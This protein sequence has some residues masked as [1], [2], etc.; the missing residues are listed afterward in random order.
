[1][2]VADQ[3][4]PQDAALGVELHCPEEIQSRVAALKLVEEVPAR[5]IGRPVVRPGPERVE[6]LRRLV[7]AVERPEVEA[8]Q[9]P[10]PPVVPLLGGPAQN[11]QRLRAEGEREGEVAG[12]AQGGGVFGKESPPCTHEGLVVKV[13]D[14]HIQY[15]HG[16]VVKTQIRVSDRKLQQRLLRILAAERAGEPLRAL[17]RRLGQV[18]LGQHEVVE[19]IDLEKRVA[20]TFGTRRVPRPA[21]MDRQQLQRG[22]AVAV[23]V[24][25]EFSVPLRLP[26]LPR[27][28]HDLGE[29]D[30]RR[31][32][33][34]HRPGRPPECV[35]GVGVVPQGPVQVPGHEIRRGVVG[36]QL[37]GPPRVIEPLLVAGRAQRQVG[38]SQQRAAVPG[39]RF[40]SLLEQG[41]RLF[42]AAALR[43]LP[44]LEDQLVRLGNALPRRGFHLEWARQRPLGR[45]G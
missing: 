29:A 32:P 35:A 16:I 24:A 31:G 45:I 21:A 2:K 33:V 18:A 3:H 14:R 40:G 7:I 12:V 13:A 4:D 30:V 9:I 43:Q 1:M 37:E 8:E 23:E 34:P 22:N 5:R 20:G 15:G 19:R 36:V 10:P 26:P 25:C 6:R 11:R 27:P 44:R 38:E 42:V 39:L 17:R 41:A 28:G